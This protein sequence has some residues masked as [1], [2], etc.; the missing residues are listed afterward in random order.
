MLSIETLVEGVTTGRVSRRGFLQGAVA[1][2]LSASGAV[3]LLEACTSGTQGTS[4]ADLTFVV[5][6]YGV[7]TIKDNIKKLEAKVS[8]LHVNF[9]DFA[10]TNYHDTM[11]ARFAA[12][13]PTDVCYGSDHW[14]SEW[15]AAGW[16]SPLEQKYP[17]LNAYTSDYFPYVIQG[18]TYQ[19]KNYGIPYYADTWAFLYNEDHLKKAGISQPPTT[20]GI[21]SSCCSHRTTPARSKSGRRW[22]FHSTTATFSMTA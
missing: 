3:A 6:S 12:K 7:E 18:M 2:G 13:T 19:D 22:S 20:W 10:W 15:A 16:L 14:L 21:P 4:A 5:W 17:N 8:G 9:Q 11:V 1:L